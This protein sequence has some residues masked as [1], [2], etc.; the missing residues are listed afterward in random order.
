LFRGYGELRN[1]NIKG[2]YGFLELD[3]KQ[4]AADAI[5]D[6]NGK[7]FNGGSRIRVE[8]ANAYTGNDGGGDRDHQGRG[9]RRVSD[10]KYRRTNYRLVVEN[11]SSRTS[12]QDLKDYMK[13][14]GDI[15]YTTVNRSNNGEGLVEFSDREGMESALRELDDTKLDGRRIRLREEKRSRSRSTRRRDGRRSESKRSRSREERRSQDRPRRH[16]SPTPDERSRSMSTD[17]VRMSGRERSFSKRPR[18]GDD[19][20]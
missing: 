1:V 13:T 5:R 4:D 10:G 19:S 7:S 11:I 2:Q 20:E 9:D 18:G 15:T 16:R 12:W 17:H 6:V 3:D 14:A 8:Y